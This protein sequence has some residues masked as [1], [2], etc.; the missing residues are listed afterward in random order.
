[1]AHIHAD[2]QGFDFHR[3]LI[4]H[5]WMGRA[6]GKFGNWAGNT[7]ICA[8]A[9]GNG[10]ILALVGIFYGHFEGAEGFA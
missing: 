1:M 8:V 2:M 7:K 5:R 10:Q 4:K 6:M 9:K 3:R